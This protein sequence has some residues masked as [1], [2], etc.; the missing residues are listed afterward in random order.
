[1]ADDVVMRFEMPIESKNWVS[2]GQ[3]FNTFFL[4]KYPAIIIRVFLFEKIMTVVIIASRSSVSA[5][6]VL[7]YFGKVPVTTVGTG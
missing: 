5:R 1:M 4:K 3:P 6:G 7:P 2:L